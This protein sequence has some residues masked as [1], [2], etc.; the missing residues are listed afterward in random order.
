[1]PRK[2]T[3]SDAVIEQRRIA[4]TARQAR[5]GENGRSEYGRTRA[6]ARWSPETPEKPKRRKARNVSL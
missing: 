4:G 3:I 6:K 2:Y 1:M 5:L